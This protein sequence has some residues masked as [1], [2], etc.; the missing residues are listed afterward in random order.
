MRGN[1]RSQHD[2]LPHPPTHASKRASKAATERYAPSL[3][4]PRCRTLSPELRHCAPTCT[5]IVIV[6]QV[7]VRG[8]GSGRGKIF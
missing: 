5:S 7:A 6:P 3:C 1:L 2:V 4:A 8:A